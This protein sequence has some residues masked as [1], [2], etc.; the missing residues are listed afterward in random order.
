MKKT[1]FLALLL[2]LAGWLKGNSVEFQSPSFEKPYYR[3]IFQYE[4][5]NENILL[6][7]IEL[8]GK[9]F[10]S[11]FVFKQG[12]G[13]DSSKA[14]EKGI[15]DIHLDHAWANRALYTINFLY[16]QGSS[17]KIR[18]I[19]IK[20]IS[21]EKGGIPAGEEGFCRVFVAEESAGLER[22]GEISYLTLA[23]AKKELENESLIILDGSTLIDYQILEVKE[24]T[25][26]E[27]A[28]KDH[29]PTLTYKIAMP[30]DIGPYEKKLI[31]VLKGKAESAEEEGFEISGEGVG[32]TVK[33]KRISLEL[34]PE[35]GQ[36]NIIE[37]LKE[38]IK[39]TNEAGVIHWNPDVF[40]PGIAWDHSFNWNPPPH[41]EE[42]IGK[43][44]YINSRKG[45]MQSIKDV[46]LEVKYL[47][48]A[49]SP[50]FIS[51]TKM[52]VH[53]DLG[54]IAVR[55]DEMVLDKKLFDFLAYKNKKNEVIQ[56]P[57]KEKPLRPDGLVHVA[58]EDAD[59]VGLL[60]AEQKYGFFSLRIKSTNSNLNSSGD[61][62]NKPGTYFYAP[63]DGKYVYWVRPLLY[64][65]SEYP[66][67][68]LLT[69]VPEGSFFYEKNA[70]I[71]LS[72]T[73]DFPNT[74]DTLLKKL[75]NPVRIY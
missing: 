36:V 22:K 24:S 25:P 55:N 71:L 8:N 51:E 23:A 20:G 56:M 72:L 74:L 47:L 44:L 32:K 41:F 75:K 18:K 3:I 6:K 21:P 67:R 13:V 60:N 19:E 50:Y 70:Y 62:L 27:K 7:E 54:V 5:K 68:N 2:L 17:P 16:Q 33:S 30:L 15:Y 38:G 40:I 64:T 14:L 4:V 11:F 12:K 34:H 52:T 39:L 26:D 10:E 58:P 29:P 59:W 35:S 37:Y 9:K 69:F 73:K 45:P 57:L 43:F 66:T 1:I 48:E 46:T 49:N 63:S 42:N 65:W 31:L 53:K 61:W 28:A